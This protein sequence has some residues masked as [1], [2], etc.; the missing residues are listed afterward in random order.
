MKVLE[1][2]DMNNDIMIISNEEIISTA[3]NK[4]HRWDLRADSIVNTATPIQNKI[5]KI[6][7][8]IDKSRIF[9]QAAEKFV[10]VIDL[11]TFNNNFT[12]KFQ[13]EISAFGNSSQMDR[14]GVGFV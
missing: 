8:D 9:I 5:E 13:K 2:L 4:L 12:I 3:D 14:Y 11:K 6:S 7:T 10:K 1:N